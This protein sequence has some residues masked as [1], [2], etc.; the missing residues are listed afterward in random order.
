MLAVG[1]HSTIVTGKGVWGME[2]RDFRVDKRSVGIFRFACPTQ[3]PSFVDFFIAQSHT[4][5]RP[6]QCPEC[7]QNFSEAATLQQ[8]KRRHTQ[9]SRCISEI[10]T[11]T[12]WLSTL[13]PYKCDFPGC[14]K[15]FAITGALTIH[16]RVHNGHKPFKCI[17]C[18]RCAECWFLVCPTS[19]N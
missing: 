11:G 2:K 15:C 12:C 10:R 14:G 6:F 8:H 4:G 1:S 18:N 17:Y 5:Y 16:K 3:L 19:E 7:L 13:E 9:E